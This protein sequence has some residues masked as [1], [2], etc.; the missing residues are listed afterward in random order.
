MGERADSYAY[1]RTDLA[2]FE[3]FSLE[4]VS[5][6]EIDTRLDAGER[7]TTLDIP[8]HLDRQ[9]V[10]E[11]ETGVALYRLVQLFGTPNVPGLTA[12]ADQR[13][14][15]RTT[16]QYLF[17]VGFDREDEDIPEEFLLSM[18]D[19]KTNVSTGLSAW[20]SDGGGIT[21]PAADI[22]A[23]PAVSPPPDEFL[24]RVVQLVLNVTE[25]PVPATFEGLWV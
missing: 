3:R 11:S 10:V 22:E 12:G 19:Y 4:P 21:E 17:R 7:L 14:R 24:V 1:D 23:C 6:T 18:Y 15:E 9:M 13:E 16:W 25:E 5:P 2:F 20:D 8:N